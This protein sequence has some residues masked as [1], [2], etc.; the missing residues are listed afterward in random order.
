MGLGGA[1][2][3]YTGGKLGGGGGGGGGVCLFT[4]MITYSPT[5]DGPFAVNSLRTFS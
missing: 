3:S 5:K 2:H 1:S 4:Q